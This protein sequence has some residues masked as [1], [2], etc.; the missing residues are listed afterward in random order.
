MNYRLG[1]VGAGRITEESHLPAALA[2]VGVDVAALVDTSLGRLDRCCERFGIAPKRADNTGDILGDVDGLI[3]ATPND[4]HAAIAIQCLQGGVDVL[5]EKP[6]AT[7]VDEG[8]AI[9][10]AAAASGRTVAVG[11]STRF[12]DSVIQMETLLRSNYFGRVKR[13]AYQFGTRGGWNPV[14]NYILDAQA[15]GGGVIPVSGSHFL[16]RMLAWFGYPDHITCQDDA[17]GGPEANAVAT[18]GYG[19][20]ADAFEGRVRFSKTTA[21]PAGFVM[22]TDAGMVVLPDS[23]A[24]GGIRL[25][26]TGLDGTEVRVAPELPYMDP[27]KGNYHRQ[28]EDFVDASQTGRPP[29]VTGEQGVDSLR[30]IGAMYACRTPLEITTLVAKEAN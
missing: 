17:C 2:A 29:R 26:P 15:T 6:L 25:R 13:F 23:A 27:R 28:I 8:E 22:D 18:F 11:Y 12:R 7:T 1:I 14:S 16:D 5:I 10:Q 3:I 20:G 24:A 21:L 4:S 9:C 19:T 30:L